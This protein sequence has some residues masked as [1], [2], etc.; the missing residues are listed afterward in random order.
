MKQLFVGILLILGVLMFASFLL[1]GRASY[2]MEPEVWAHDEQGLVATPTYA[3]HSSKGYN[4]EIQGPLDVAEDRAAALDLLG[5]RLAEDLR[6]AASKSRRPH[7]ANVTSPSES[8]KHGLS[9]RLRSH[10]VQ[11]ASRGSDAYRIEIYEDREYESG[12]LLVAEARLPRQQVY[13]VLMQVPDAL[14]NELVPMAHQT[15]IRFKSSFMGST[16]DAA[17]SG[18]GGLSQRIG[19]EIYRIAR[20][21]GWVETDDEVAFRRL[22]HERFPS[23]MLIAQGEHRMKTEEIDV[24]G[25]PY[26]ESY[27]VWRAETQDLERIGRSVASAVS[28]KERLPFIRGLITLAL[29]LVLIFGWLKTDWW[30]KG[31]HSFLTKVGFATVF[32]LGAALIFNLRLDV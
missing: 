22:L 7:V 5:E 24:D 19:R 4:S 6:D 9:S 17:Q 31:Q 30:L 13:G 14:V 23:I 10:N 15:Q 1:V 21:H 26:F 25:A 16:S 18:I 32:V 12:P 3:T 2:D 20:S 28:A 8:L 27:F 29:L 11:L